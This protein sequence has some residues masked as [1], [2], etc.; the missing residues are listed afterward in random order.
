MIK[1]EIFSFADVLSG[2]IRR[3]ANYYQKELSELCFVFVCHGRRNFAGHKKI[4][5]ETRK[6]LNYKVVCHRMVMEELGKIETING[7]FKVS[8]KEVALFHFRTGYDP[9][10]FTTEACW[11]ARRQIEISRA[12][13]SPSL[14]VLKMF[15]Y[16]NFNLIHQL[17]D[18]LIS[19]L[20]SMKWDALIR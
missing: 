5:I 3:F 7:V 1:L 12:I 16:F 4:E 14:E 18:Q 20:Y 15:L 13:K 6:L 17:V 9:S 19:T 8:D 2:A 11:Q 10:S